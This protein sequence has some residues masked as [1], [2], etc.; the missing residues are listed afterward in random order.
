VTPFLRLHA[1]LSAVEEVRIVAAVL[2]F[3]VALYWGVAAIYE[4][5]A[6]TKPPGIFGVSLLRSRRPEPV[7]STSQWRKAGLFLLA[8]AGFSVLRGIRLL[9][10]WP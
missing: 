3:S 9:Q 5:V 4:I 1:T 8:M 10:G 2:L 6:T 7:L